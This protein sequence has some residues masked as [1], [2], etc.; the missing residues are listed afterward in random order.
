MGYIRIRGFQES[1][2]DLDICTRTRNPVRN[3]PIKYKHLYGSLSSTNLAAVL[4]EFIYQR[5]SIIAD[6]VLLNHFIYHFVA[7][8]MIFMCIIERFPQI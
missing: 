3:I 5:L 7:K 6:I 1:D 4:Y 8:T 2:P